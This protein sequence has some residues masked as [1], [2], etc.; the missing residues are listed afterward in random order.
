MPRLPLGGVFTTA[1]NGPGGRLMLSE[2]NSSLY[3][4]SLLAP[5]HIC[6]C[7]KNTIT[8]H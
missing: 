5:N 3:S 6:S 8:E 2:D 4:S 7:L 1:Y